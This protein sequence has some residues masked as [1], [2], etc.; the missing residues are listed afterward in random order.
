LC[1]TFLVIGYTTTIAGGISSRYG[2]RDGPA[3]NATFSPDFEVVYVPKICALLV[4]DRGNRLIRQVNLKTQD[5]A[6]ETQ[7]HL[8]KCSMDRPLVFVI[9]PLHKRQLGATFCAGPGRIQSL[10]ICTINYTYFTST[11]L[12]F[13]GQNLLNK[14]NQLYYYWLL[15]HL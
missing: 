1:Y 15:F 4:T 11:L 13:W 7:T 6:P 8:G 14:K 10:Y 3:Q 12:L 2:H 9:H 5:C